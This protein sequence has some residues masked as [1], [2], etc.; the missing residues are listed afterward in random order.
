MNPLCYCCAFRLPIH[1]PE[2]RLAATNTGDCSGIDGPCLPKALN[3]FLS[4]FRLMHT[5]RLLH[6]AET[7]CRRGLVAYFPRIESL[8]L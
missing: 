3:V 7:I 4:C 5:Q 1:L 2:E 8:A 6:G